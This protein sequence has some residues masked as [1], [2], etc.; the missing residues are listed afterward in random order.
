MPTYT[1]ILCA[2]ALLL[3]FTLLSPQGH[4]EPEDSAQEYGTEAS[5]TQIEPKD[6]GTSQDDDSEDFIDSEN[7]EMGLQSTGSQICKIGEYGCKKC[8]QD[9]Y[10]FFVK[11][12]DARFAP[13]KKC[14]DAERNWYYNILSTCLKNC[15]WP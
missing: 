4:C 12:C 3:S 13:R 6:L 2:S 10:Q 5:D 7:E 11:T 9:N 1:K 14:P 8:C 15:G